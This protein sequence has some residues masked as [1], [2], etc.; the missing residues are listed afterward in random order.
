MN[1]YLYYYISYAMIAEL[2]LN[3]IIMKKLNYYY[4]AKDNFLEKLAK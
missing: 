1:S 2:I 3:K 4:D